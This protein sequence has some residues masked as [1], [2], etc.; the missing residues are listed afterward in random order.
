M[1]RSHDLER[2]A[3]PACWVSNHS[4]Q[5]VPAFTFF[6][7][8]KGNA[9]STLPLGVLKSLFYKEGERWLFV[10]PHLPVTQRFL[11]YFFCLCC[12]LVAKW[13]QIVCDSMDCSP[14]GSSVR[15]IFQVR[16]LEWVA[17]SFSRGF[18]WSN[19][20]IKPRSPAFQVVFCTA[21][22]FFTEW[23]TGFVYLFIWL[24]QIFSC[25]MWDLVPWPGIKPGP[26]AL[27]V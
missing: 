23:A 14:I 16:I 3:A 4:R 6:P 17:I 7:W 13:C 25:S 18:T 24:C 22:W 21:G 27:G 15:G 2:L 9:R 26:P 5:M 19:T 20:G 12:F 1:L 10:E 8:M 11:L